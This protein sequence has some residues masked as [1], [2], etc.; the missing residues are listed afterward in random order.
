MERQLDALITAYAKKMHMGFLHLRRTASSRWSKGF[1]PSKKLN[2]QK[3]KKHTY[4][5][6]S[7]SLFTTGQKQKKK[8]LSQLLGVQDS[9][10]NYKSYEFFILML[11]FTIGGL[12]G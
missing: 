3:F 11:G 1:G 5:P 10:R 7:S 12:S 8:K 9:L 2:S 6:Q 4:K